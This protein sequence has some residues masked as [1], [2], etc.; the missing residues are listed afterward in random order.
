MRLLSGE[1]FLFVLRSQ[2]S[3]H[4]TGW[5]SNPNKC[6]TLWPGCAPV[7]PHITMCFLHYIPAWKDS[8]NILLASLYWEK[9]VVLWVISDSQPQQTTEHMNKCSQFSGFLMP[10]FFLFSGSFWISYFL[11]PCTFFLMFLCNDQTCLT[12]Q[13]VFWNIAMIYFGYFYGHRRSENV[14]NAFLL[15]KIFE[16]SKKI[17][18]KHHVYW[19]HL[20]HP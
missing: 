13:Q 4:F 12:F 5:F 8:S 17:T 11:H 1:C 20:L 7:I 14:K 10:T 16:N 2:K 6:C 3:P 15:F 19:E 9:Y 18:T